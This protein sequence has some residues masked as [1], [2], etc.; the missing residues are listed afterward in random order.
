M[1]TS[2]QTQNVVR[3]VL[4]LVSMLQ[5]HFGTMRWKVRY[6]GITIWPSDLLRR[7]IVM[8]S[9]I[10]WIRRELPH[11]NCSCMQRS[12]KNEVIDMFYK[13]ILHCTNLMGSYSMSLHVPKNL[14]PKWHSVGN[15]VRLHRSKPFQQSCIDTCSTAKTTEQ[16]SLLLLAVQRQLPTDK[17]TRFLPS[18]NVNHFHHYLPHITYYIHAGATRHSC[19]HRLHRWRWCIKDWVQQGYRHLQKWT[20]GHLFTV[21]GGGHIDTWQPL[22]Q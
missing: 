10:W 13:Y 14:F 6:E 15:T 22:Y 11:T 5:K 9:W 16:L 19:H 8:P 4:W 7:L 12:A 18:S 21:N 20:R 2:F 17:V 3:M 1:F